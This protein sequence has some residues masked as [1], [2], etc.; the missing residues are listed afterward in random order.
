MTQ[1][2][3]QTIKRAA[4]EIDG[5]LLCG[6]TIAQKLI[7]KPGSEWYV[8]ILVHDNGNTITIHKAPS[9]GIIEVRKNARIIKTEAL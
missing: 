2:E 1:K 5:F 3:Y 6:Y 4:E 7:H 8:T 9:L